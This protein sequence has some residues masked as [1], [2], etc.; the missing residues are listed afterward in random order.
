MQSDGAHGQT[1]ANRFK[2]NAL[3]TA[4]YT[5]G[6]RFYYAS[7]EICAVKKNKIIYLHIQKGM[8]TS[9]KFAFTKKMRLCIFDK[10]H[11]KLVPLQNRCYYKG[12]IEALIASYCRHDGGVTKGL[13]VDFCGEYIPMS[14]VAEA[15][16]VGSLLTAYHNAN[17][18]DSA[19]VRGEHI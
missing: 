5:H 9:H 13:C 11:F 10:G 16:V 15:C 17:V 3:R 12:E 18:R 14:D 19:Q 7:L 1:A 8:P 4:K 2:I 6:V